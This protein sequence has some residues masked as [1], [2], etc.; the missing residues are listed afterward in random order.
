MASKY[1]NDQWYTERDS[2]LWKE[3]ERIVVTAASV[4]KAGIREALYDNST[5]P[6]I[7]DIQER[8]RT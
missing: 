1:I 3:R 7:S 4:I 5:Y 6:L 8:E 2:D